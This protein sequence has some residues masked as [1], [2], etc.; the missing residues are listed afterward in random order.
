MINELSPQIEA[1]G[2]VAQVNI[3][4]GQ[5]RAVIVDVDPSKIQARGLRTPTLSSNIKA[6]K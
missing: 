5:L 2:G 4:G 1:A 3:S 6:E